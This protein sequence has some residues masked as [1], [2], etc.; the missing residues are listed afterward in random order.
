MSKL[1]KTPESEENPMKGK[2]IEE[3]E[4]YAPEG[5]APGLFSDV[6]LVMTDGTRFSIEM[7]KESEAHALTIG[8]ES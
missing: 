8:D 2:T 4:C 3:V 6:V 7:N 1:G 5:W